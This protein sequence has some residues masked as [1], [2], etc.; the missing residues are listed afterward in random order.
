MDRINVCF[1]P[2][3]NYVIPCIVAIQSL[4]LRNCNCVKVDIFIL[5]GGLTAENKQ[6]IETVVLSHE[7]ASVSFV[8]VDDARF[9]DFSSDT[10]GTATAYRL[11]IG[12]LLPH[13][14][15]VLY[16]DADTIV[17]KS[18]SDMYFCNLGTNIIGMAPDIWH[19]KQKKRFPCKR[20]T[21]FNAGVCLIDLKKWRDKKISES[22]FDFYR[23][24]IDACIYP[25][26][27]PINIVLDG[28]VLQLDC[29]YNFGWHWDKNECL[30][31]F[32]SCDLS[33][34]A[35][36]HYVFNKPW[37]SSCIHPYAY[38][39]RDVAKTLPEIIRVKAAT[40]Q[41]KLIDKVNIYIFGMP[42]LK[43][44][45]YFR[46]KEWKLFGFFILFRIIKG[47]GGVSKFFLFGAIPVAKVK[48]RLYSNFAD[49]NI[50]KNSIR[51][52]NE[53]IV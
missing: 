29:K 6:T 52:S 3:N 7:N 47:D 9:K 42:I 12:E 39:Y 28:M 38:L 45:N 49:V 10:W 26:Q 18:V 21:Y 30:E 2:D 41:Y 20:Q 4:C 36:V 17:C 23:K 15:R 8:D 53:Y 25:D 51:Y 46:K 1:A 44:Y 33:E 37:W 11:K 35:I 43:I 34:A 14:D 48:S 32:G 50:V 13:I 24:N 19:K 5:D 40:L 27:D 16:L 22:L 31:S